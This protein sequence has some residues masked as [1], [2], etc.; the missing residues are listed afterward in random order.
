MHARLYNCMQCT[1]L[2][3]G[4]SHENGSVLLS[5]GVETAVYSVINNFVSFA[6]RLAES[7]INSVSPFAETQAGSPFASPVLLLLPRGG[8]HTMD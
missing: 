3:S 5:C 7:R 1:C 6:S 2:I 8:P 4:R